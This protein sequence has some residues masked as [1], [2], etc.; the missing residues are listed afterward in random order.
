M[1]LNTVAELV[2]TAVPATDI[3][4]AG[5]VPPSPERTPLSVTSGSG[6]GAGG[7]VEASARTSDARTTAP[8]FIPRTSTRSPFFRSANAIGASARLITAEEATWTRVEPILNWRPATSRSASVPYAWTAL[9]GAVR[10]CESMVAT[11]ALTVTLTCPTSFMATAPTGADADT[12]GAENVSTTS[13]G[14][15]LL[16]AKLPPASAI[17]DAP[18]PSTPTISP[19]GELDVEATVP[20]IVAPAALGAGPGAG[21][22]DAAGADVPLGA[23]GVAECPPH[24]VTSAS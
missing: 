20:L 13:A 5:H 6:V 14:G 9:S 11:V 12:P 3:A 18:V 19:A 2:L 4:S 21:A 8:S 23:V 1:P 17:D 22:G 7:C 10:C 16:S 24:P 15:T